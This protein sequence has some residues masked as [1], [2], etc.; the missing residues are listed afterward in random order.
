MCVLVIFKGIEMARR[1]MLPALGIFV[2]ELRP[3][4][5][6]HWLDL[7]VVQSWFT[8]TVS[9]LTVLNST[10]L[11]R[12]IFFKWVSI[13]WCVLWYFKALYVVLEDERMQEC[14]CR[15]SG[16]CT[17]LF[18]HF[19]YSG[20]YLPWFSGPD[21]S[22]GRKPPATSPAEYWISTQQ[23]ALLQQS[24]SVS[25]WITWDSWIDEWLQGTCK[26]I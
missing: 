19:K 7:K 5:S 15:N 1:K 17:V 16:F 24:G 3:E 6:W 18:P 25:W 4:G 12:L 13:Y 8:F 20:W 14:Q 23:S 21:P 2:A 26:W 9:Y 11:C 22:S 10:Q